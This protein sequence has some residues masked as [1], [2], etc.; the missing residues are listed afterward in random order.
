M[1]YYIF[2][3][4]I[5]FAIS[6]DELKDKDNPIKLYSVLNGLLNLKNIDVYVNGSNSKLLSKDVLTEFRGRGDVI[7]V[8]PLTFSE[9]YAA[10]GLD[11]IDA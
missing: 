10:A 4:E 2:L 6:K 9:Y 1:K 5:Q 8:Y 7:H 3:D 11:I